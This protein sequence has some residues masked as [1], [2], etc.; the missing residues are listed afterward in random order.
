MI[1]TILNAAGIL[2]GGVVGLTRPRLLGLG[3]ESYIKVVLGALTVFY[4]LRLTWA[5]LSGS[6]LDVLK[7]LAVVILSL[8]L[9][10]LAGR[11]LRLQKMS[12]RLGQRARERITTA[13][14]DDPE[15]F[16]AGFK[17]CAALFCAAPLGIVGSVQEGL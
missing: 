12:N 6:F 4:G 2:A 11:G 9:G 13:R 8:S 14:A 5:S 15:R 3:A 1:G 7:Q 10:K 17:T 16:S